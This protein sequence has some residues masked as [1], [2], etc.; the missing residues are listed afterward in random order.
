MFDMWVVLLLLYIEYGFRLYSVI[1]GLLICNI[2]YMIIY[3]FF[4]NYINC[5]Y[6]LY[7]F[8]FCIKDFILRYYVSI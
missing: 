4:I 8:C 1:D 3:N 5:V 6:N 7:V 2:F